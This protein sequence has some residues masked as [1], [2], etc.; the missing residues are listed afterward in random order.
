MCNFVLACGFVLGVVSAGIGCGGGSSGGGGQVSTTT[1]LV[2]SDLH[3]GYGTPVTLTVRVTPN[4][5]ATPAGYV[6]LFD[7]GQTYGSPTKVSAGI[8]SFLSTNLPVGVHTMT[9]QYQGDAGTT[10]STSPVIAQVIAGTVALQITGTANGI[11]QMVDFQAA[12]D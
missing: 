9:A 2:S 7:N 8:A 5:N 1:S 6:Q 10:G 3:V 12:V 4:G 11:T